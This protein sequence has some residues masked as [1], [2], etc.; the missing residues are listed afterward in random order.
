MK[1][2]IASLLGGAFNALGGLLRRPTPQTITPVQLLTREQAQPWSMGGLFGTGIASR[3][4]RQG[5]S[6]ASKSVRDARRRQRAAR[7][8]NKMRLNGK[9]YGGYCPK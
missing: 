8:D 2:N 6:R 7:K 3:M 4:T 5:G 9:R 1:M